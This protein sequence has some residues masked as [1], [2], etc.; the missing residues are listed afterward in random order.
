VD[1]EVYAY[2]ERVYG[3]TC[4]LCY[5]DGNHPHHIELKSAGGS[6]DNENLVPLCADCHTE[7]HENG[8]KNYVESIW[9]GA[10][11]VRAVYAN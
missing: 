9:A 1:K 10:T 3:N 7:V 11:L 6:D 2:L 5:K 8:P 4:V